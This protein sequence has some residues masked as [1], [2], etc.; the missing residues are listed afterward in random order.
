MCLVG[1]GADQRDRYLEDDL[2]GVDKKVSP[3]VNAVT[4]FCN[5]ILYA[6]VKNENV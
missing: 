2:S 1:R 4:V 6:A 3:I 5:D